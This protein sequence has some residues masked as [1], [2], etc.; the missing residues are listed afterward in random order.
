MINDNLLSNRLNS[1]RE[2]K[3]EESQSQS[4]F[5]YTSLSI[6]NIIDLAVIFLYSVTY[7]FAEKI[8]FSTDWNFISVLTV[9]F[10][11]ELIISNIFKTKNK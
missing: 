11:T 6:N 9:G 5:Q 4:Q 3:L 8:I 10:A 2:G 1:Y 7:G